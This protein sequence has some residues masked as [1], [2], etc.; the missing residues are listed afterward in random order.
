MSEEDIALDEKRIYGDK[1]ETT[2]AYVA[3]DLGLTR[4]AVSGDQVGRVALVHR[5]TVRDVAGGDGRLLAATE[6]DVLVGGEAGFESTGF[7]PAVAVGVGPDGLFAADGD[8]RV[9]GLAGDEWR[10]IGTVEDPRRFDGACL[11]AAD[12]V[13][14]IGPDGLEPLGLSAVRDVAATGPHAA[15]ADG[16]YRRRNGSW[17]RVREGACDRVSA[18]DGTAHLVAGGDLFER[19]ETGWARCALPVA[20]PVADVAAGDVPYAVTVDGTFLVDAD[21]AATPDGAGGW[22]HR[23]LGLPAVTALAVPGGPR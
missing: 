17:T 12:G 21:P 8:G 6:T 13:H 23:S 20:E 22:R 18:I 7:G 11:A 10:S 16:L 3:S 1:R 4:V 15:T 14:R 2:V 9:A 5:G 19:T